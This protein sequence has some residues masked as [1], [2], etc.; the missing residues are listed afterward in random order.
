MLD[1]HRHAVEL[2]L[3]RERAEV[4]AAGQ[5]QDLVVVNVAHDGDLLAHRGGQ[6]E[7]DRAAWA[8]LLVAVECDGVIGVEYQCGLES[9]HVGASDQQVA[10][11]KH[12]EGKRE[13]SLCARTEQRPGFACGGC[14]GHV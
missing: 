5:V 11:S 14:D 3:E 10:V 13:R 8:G 2:V 1:L 12:L 9:E 6:H 4:A 7:R